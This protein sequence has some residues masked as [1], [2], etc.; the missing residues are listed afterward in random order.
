MEVGEKRIRKDEVLRLVREV[1]TEGEYEEVR[2][3]V[4][5]VAEG[6]EVSAVGLYEALAEG[7]V[8]VCALVDMV[9]G[10]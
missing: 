8:N 9:C 2:R 4:E 1:G 7:R 5:E 10:A 6:E 3:A